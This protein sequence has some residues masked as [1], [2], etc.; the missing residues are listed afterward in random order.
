MRQP[1]PWCLHHGDHPFRV[2]PEVSQWSS[3]SGWGV[4]R[5]Q[6]TCDTCSNKM[7]VLG[8]QP[9]PVSFPTEQVPMAGV[10]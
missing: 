9:T 3:S 1:S 8:K 7:L 5:R 4:G 2:P 6:V 10:P